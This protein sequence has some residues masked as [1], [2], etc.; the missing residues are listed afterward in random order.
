M[1]IYGIWGGQGKPKD[2]GGLRVSELKRSTPYNTYIISGLPPTPI[3]NPGLE[4]LKATAR[5]L[6]TDDLFF[7]A[8]GTGGHVFATTL[9]DHNANVVK[10][11]KIEA[12]RK[13]D[14]E[15]AAKEAEKKEIEP[16]GQT[17]Q[18]N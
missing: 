8:D 15:A 2:R 1:R 3:A 6:E 7:V 13:K 9:A 4:A 14:A 11:R 12:Q 17:E 16:A 5:P 10:W 18:S